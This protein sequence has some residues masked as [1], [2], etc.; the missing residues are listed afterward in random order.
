MEDFSEDRIDETVQHGQKNQRTAQRIRNWCK[1]ARISRS[2][3]VGFIE[4]LT[5]VPIGHMGVEC[6]H[7]PADGVHCWDLEDAA[8]NF[9]LSNCKGCDQRIP[10]AGPTIEPLIQRFE[11]REKKRQRIESAHN[12]EEARHR[13]EQIHEVE[14]L[15]VSGDDLSSQIVD[16]LVAIIEGREDGSAE[17]LVELASL[18]PEAFASDIVEYLKAQVV[19]GN[20]RLETPAMHTILRLPLSEDVKRKL[21][22][23]TFSRYGTDTSIA[24]YLEK[25]ACDLSGEDVNSVLANLGVLAFPFGGFP[26]VHREP[27]P[28]PLLAIAT[29][30]STSVE[31]VLREWLG[32]ENDSLIHSAFRVI[33][34]L[35]IHHSEIVKPFVRGVLAKLLRRDILL[36]SLDE[37]S[38]SDRLHV[39]RGAAVRLFCSFPTNADS[40]LQSL[41]VGANQT[42]LSEAERVYSGVLDYERS[43]SACDLGQA[44]EMAFNRTLWMAVD[45]PDRTMSSDAVHF[46]SYVRADLLPIATNCLDTILGAAAILSDKVNDEESANMI[47]VPTTGLEELSRF[48]V[49]NSIRSLQSNL[50]DWAFQAAIHQG[51]NGVQRVLEFYEA[52]PES[53]AETRALVVEHMGELMTSTKAVNAVL[54][55]LYGAL[56]SQEAQIRGS[57]ARTIGD[58][59]HEVRRDLPELIFEVY[60]VLLNDPKVYVH[61]RA[62]RALRVQDFPEKLK[63]SVAASLLSLIRVYRDARDDPD[64][65]VD[66]LRLYV[67]RVSDR[68]SA[69]GRT[70]EPCDWNPRSAG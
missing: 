24:N 50:F 51:L 23:K 70:R 61:Q 55:Y 13:A 57:A 30:H 43:D 49:R 69:L 18:A 31:E 11:E 48:Q 14:R 2:G 44:K 5:G 59:P 56:T 66:C 27:R 40:D 42:A 41:L 45:H 26:V 63:K 12:A 67:Q 33:A 39:L 68:F 15:R 36:P 38:G 62:V 10:G 22:V 8:I 58:M 60:V 3:G 32:S 16:L 7:A 4:E 65:V 34:V 9:Y 46:F 19:G 29:H 52:L 17:T 28:A 21:A 1:N 6:D 35:A 25:A 47:D 20:S 64:F 54:P 53:E 37:Y